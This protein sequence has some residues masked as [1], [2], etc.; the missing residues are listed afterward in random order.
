MYA[1]GNGLNIAYMTGTAYV[2]NSARLLRECLS[3]AGMPGPG[4]HCT[5]DF[6][7][8]PDYH[9]LEEYLPPLGSTTSA[10]KYCAT[11]FRVN[12]DQTVTDT[13]EACIN[14]HP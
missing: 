13:G 11:T 7:I 6:M 12:S 9:L 2:H 3:G 5:G 4:G 1:N 8:Y 14:V 10:G